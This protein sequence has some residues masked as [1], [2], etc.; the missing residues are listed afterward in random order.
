[1]YRYSFW[2]YTK[3][4]KPNIIIFQFG[5]CDACRRA[6][7]E[8]LLKFF[9]KFEKVGKVYQS[10]AS[11]YHYY[12]TKF[13]NIH[14][15]DICTFEAVIKKICSLRNTKIAFIPIAPVGNYLI[16]KSYGILSDVK[17]YNRVFYKNARGHNVL[18]LSAYKGVNVDD[19]ILKKDGHH[20]NEKGNEIVYNAVAKYIDELL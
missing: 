8:K 20:L 13:W 4:L 7:P 6:T 11:K 2:I 19:I 15:N 5:I 17:E 3:F 1:M 12:L 9:Q 10:Y 16:N 14:Y 18:V